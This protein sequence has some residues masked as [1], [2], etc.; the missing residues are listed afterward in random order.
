[1]ASAPREQWT[2]RTGFLLAAVGSA[3]G[4]GNMWRFSYLTAEHGGGAFVLLYLA[5]TLLIG[6]PVLLAELVLGRGAGRS[7]VEALAHYGGRSWRPLGWLFVATGLLILGYYSVI[8]GWTLRYALTAVIGGFPEDPGAFFGEISSGPAA[9][10]WHLLFMGITVAVVAGGVKGGIERTSLVLMPLLFALVIGLAVYAA[11]L[12]GAA[13]GYEFYLAIDFSQIWSFE[14]LHAAAGQAFFSLSL[15]MGAMLTYASY[16]PRRE[17]LPNASLVIAGADFAVAFVAGLAVFPLIF[18]LGLSGD[19]GESTVG[20]LFIT[21]PKTFAGMGAA[22]R[23]VGLL[24]FVA[25]AV[26]ALTSAIS[27]LEVVVAS[28]MDGLGWERRRA[29]L[30]VG[31][32]IA[33]VGIPAALSLDVLGTMDQIAGNLLLVLG[34]LFLAVFVGWV[35]RDPMAE[36]QPG[37]EGVGWF[38]LWRWLLRIPVPIIL[39]IVLWQ[40]LQALLGE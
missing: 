6:L 32:A 38:A 19:V 5:L 35:M 16:L 4:L 30:L 10:V 33:L 23:V 7:P 9:L 40:S 26:G 37:A 39:V 1:M 21:L 13:S 17:H 22:G 3:V 20:A 29:A 36:V 8:A 2:S 18:A 34:G 12:D 27:L 11:A 31:P 28:V 14:T 25:L 24:F 15:G